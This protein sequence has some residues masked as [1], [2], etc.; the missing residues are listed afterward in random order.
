[1]NQKTLTALRGSIKKWER[2]GA[3]TGRDKG[4]AN[5]PLCKRFGE[6]CYIDEEN[7]LCPVAFRSGAKG[8]QR[9]PYTTWKLTVGGRFYAD[10]EKGVKAKTLEQRRAARVELKFLKSLLPK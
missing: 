7:E 10:Y 4:A 5:C 8:C 3:G 1:M 6:E 2:I 9:T